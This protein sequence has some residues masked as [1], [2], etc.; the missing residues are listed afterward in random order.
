MNVLPQIDIQL[1]KWTHATS[2]LNPYLE[3]ARAR[4]VSTVEILPEKF[5]LFYGMS[6]MLGVALSCHVCDVGFLRAG[7]FRFAPVSFEITILLIA[8]SAGGYRQCRKQKS[9]KEVHGLYPIGRNLQYSAVDL[10]RV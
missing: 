5:T 7:T 4:L 3:Y 9:P 10:N 8:A 2:R 6:K 1:G